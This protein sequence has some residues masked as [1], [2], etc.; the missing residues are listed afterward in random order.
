MYSGRDFVRLYDART[1]SPGHVRAF[2]DFG[3]VPGVAAGA[4]R[5][6]RFE[7]LHYLYPVLRAARRGPR[8]SAAAPHA[9]S[10]RLAGR[11]LGLAAGGGGPP[12]APRVWERF[13]EE[14]PLLR[15]GPGVGG[16]CP[17]S[18]SRSALV[19][20]EG[21]WYSVPR[22]GGPAGDGADRH[23]RVD[24]AAAARRSYTPGSPSA[25]AGWTTFGELAR[26]PQAR[27]R[28]SWSRRWASPAALDAAGAEQGAQEGARTL[29]RCCGPC[30][31]T[32]RS[33]CATSWSRSSSR[34]AST[35]SPCSVCSPRP[36]RRRQ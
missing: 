13:A 20:V 36:G 10:R 14:R 23:R 33:A 27:W 22:L 1:R 35:S 26:K 25:A 5:A 2:A 4:A 28:R 34:S 16:G 12:P 6:E 11:A 24:A 17:A 21:A 15:P 19:R 3:G 31:S 32:A 7:A 30:T 29:A 8:S 18:V 9:D